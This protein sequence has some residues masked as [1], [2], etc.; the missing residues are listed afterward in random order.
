M[1]TAKDDTRLSP[2]TPY[3]DDYDDY[4]DSDLEEDGGVLQPAALNSSVEVDDHPVTDPAN[5]DE[6]YIVTL[7]CCS[8]L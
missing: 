7:F 5:E 1:L 6:M 2:E 8:A 3:W 4:D